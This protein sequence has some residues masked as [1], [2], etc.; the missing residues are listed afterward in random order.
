MCSS[1]HLKSSALCLWEQL[2]LCYGS[3]FAS[4]VAHWGFLELAVLRKC[5]VPTPF[6]M[7]CDRE[8]LRWGPST[9]CFSQLY[10]PWALP[11]SFTSYSHFPFAQHLPLFSSAILS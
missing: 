6:R 2:Q 4:C 1:I 10:A 5:V 9:Q 3:A 11:H 8:L 7:V